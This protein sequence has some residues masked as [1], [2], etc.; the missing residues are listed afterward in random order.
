MSSE[1]QPSRRSRRRWFQFGLRG[2]LL[3]TLLAAVIVAWKREPLARWV[4]SLWPAPPPQPV[5][6]YRG[7]GWS[8]IVSA[9][10]LE[11]EIQRCTDAAAPHL[12]SKPKWN[13]GHRKVRFLYS[14]IAVCFGVIAEYDGPV[15]FR[16]EAL[17]MRDRLARS[18]ANSKVNT[19]QSM[20][21]ARLCLSELRRLQSGAGVST[22]LSNDPSMPRYGVSEIVQL[23][24]RIQICA[25]PEDDD[26]TGLESWTS[27]ANRFQAAKPEVI[28]EAEMLAV[29]NHVLQDASSFPDPTFIDSGW[30]K[31]A[32]EVESAALEVVVAAETDN[33]SLARLATGKITKACTGCHGQYR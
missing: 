28:H 12:A 8:R 14:T 4:E 11:R 33:Y 26:H 5:A 13:T 10:T 22:S 17:A 3:V 15:E 25:R 27:D 18:A 32:K 1:Q 21:E 19:E 7:A 20:M 9:E 24:R 6:R 31:F 29:L 2:L 30:L 23:M 16:E